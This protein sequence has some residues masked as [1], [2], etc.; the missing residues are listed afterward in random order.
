MIAFGRAS[1]PIQGWSVAPH[2]GGMSAKK[3]GH[4]SKRLA[5]Y[6]RDGGHVQSSAVQS[7]S[8]E[9]LG[10]V[11]SYFLGAFEFTSEVS[12]RETHPDVS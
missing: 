4:V 1:R 2:L 7:Q 3:A 9:C 11:L 12:Q 5:A 6:L 8:P 10:C